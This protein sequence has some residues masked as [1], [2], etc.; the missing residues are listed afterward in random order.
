MRANKSNTE[1]RNF[2][3]K[4]MSIGF[5]FSLGS[6][7]AQSAM[8]GEKRA[9]PSLK[10]R[11]ILFTWGGWPGH[12]PEVFAKYFDEWLKGEGA[13]VQ[14]FN[15]T[16]PYADET[17]MA[18]ID[19]VIQSITMDEIPDEHAKGLLAAIRENGTGMAGWHGGMCDSFRSNTE[20]QFMTGGQFVSH[21]GGKVDHTVD[22]TDTDD[23]ITEGLS[24]FKINS[25]QYYMH[26]DPNVKVLATTQFNGN[27]LPWIDGATIP[28]V[29]KKMHGKGR[30]FYSSLGHNLAD[31][32]EI[33]ESFAIVKRG[34]RWASASKYEKPER[35]LNPVY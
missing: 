16:E 20:Y 10:G 29:W 28:V 33:P 22:V 34:I 23:E 35:W 19:L 7:L 5:G 1:R 9:L 2:I 25:E 17:L 31:I 15:S 8:A 11:K 3:A 14:V 27:I 32:T 24:S 4:A 30:V 6:G 18:G 21:P 12:E 26:I 13:S